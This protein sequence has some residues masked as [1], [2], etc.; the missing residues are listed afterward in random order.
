MGAAL[1][2]GALAALAPRTALAA[3]LVRIRDPEA[4]RILNQALRGNGWWNGASIDRFEGKQYDE[5]RLKKLPDGG[6]LTYVGGEGRE[7]FAHEDVARTVWD[8]QDK[9]SQHFESAIASTT[10]GRGPDPVVGREYRDRYMLL[11]FGLFYGRQIQRMYRYDLPDGRTLLPFEKLTSGFTDP[12]TWRRYLAV[13]DREEQA[14]RDG[15]RLRSV[16]D[17]FIDIDFL[18]GVFI[19]EPGVS[20]TTRVS[21]MAKIGFKPG[22]SWVA[23]VGSKIPPVIKSGL[24]GGFDASVS[25]CRAVKAG[26]YD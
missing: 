14:A 15:D 16:F 7:D 8:H 3:P 2:T 19:V 13:R 11:D 26:R 4:D 22:N 24:R 18:Y 5:I 1:G 9:L 10:L 20:R 6:Y 21:M 17:S 12:S 25:I 23:S